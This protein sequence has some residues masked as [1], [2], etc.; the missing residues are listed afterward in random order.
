MLWVESRR[1][2][3]GRT[4][5]RASGANCTSVPHIPEGTLLTLAAMVLEDSGL[6]MENREQAELLA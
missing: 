5:E 1:H 4:T 2:I 3:T 6:N